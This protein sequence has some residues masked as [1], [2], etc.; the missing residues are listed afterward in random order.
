MILTLPE[1]CANFP[2][3]PP[4]LASGLESDSAS[5]VDRCPAVDSQPSCSGSRPESG[6]FP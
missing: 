3:A 1:F 2:G 6:T 4:P 5:G